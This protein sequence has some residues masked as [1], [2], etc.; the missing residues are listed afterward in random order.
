[1]VSM[2]VAYERSRGIGKGAELLW[3]P[4]EMAHD[5][6]RFRELSRA[7][8]TIIA[9]RKALLNDQVDLT[10]RPFPK[11]DQVIV[12]TRGPKE[13]IAI[14]DVDV[15]NSIEEALAMARHDPLVIGGGEVY[16]SALPYVDIIYATEV[17]ADLPHDEHTRFPELSE[18]EWEKTENMFVPVGKE[19]DIPSSR[20]HNTYP[21]YQV[22]Y[23]RKKSR[24]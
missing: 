22:T 19:N 9:G 23:I 21:S 2:V 18:T 15:A 8:G 16:R 6:A 20:K 7:A 11:I 12:L 5:M 14:P 3:G 10:K 17:D 24:A 1:M 13:S 4:Y